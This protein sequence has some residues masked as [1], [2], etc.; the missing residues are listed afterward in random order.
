MGRLGPSSHLVVAALVAVPSGLL[1]GWQSEGHRPELICTW[2][3]VFFATV[4]GALSDPTSRSA[5]GGL[6]VAAFLGCL[7][8]IYVPLTLQSPGA[9]LLQG[10]NYGPWIWEASVVT[11]VATVCFIAGLS[12]AGDR[13]SLAVTDASSPRQATSPRLQAA[14]LVLLSV[15]LVAS[16]AVSGIGESHSATQPAAYLL[17]APQYALGAG[18]F[19]YYL[20]RSKLVRR[21]GGVTCLILTASFAA[22]G[23]RYLALV[24]AAALLILTIWTRGPVRLPRARMFW[25]AVLVGFVALSILGVTRQSGSELSSTSVITSGIDSSDVVLP[26]AAVIK[27]TQ[28]RGFLLGTSYTYLVIQV[29][30]RQVWPGKPTPPTVDVIGEFSDV[31]EGR[32]FPLW[33]EMYLNFG[34][35]GVV[36]GMAA[37]GYFYRRLLR[38]W[39]TRRVDSPGLDVAMALCAPLLVQWMSRGLF[40]QLIYNSAGLLVVPLMLARADRQGRAGTRRGRKI[41]AGRYEGVRLGPTFETSYSGSNLVSARSGI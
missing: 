4:W 24:G 17:Y 19:L 12:L 3:L 32:A 33:G 29:V 25:L 13:R 28:D 34:W 16:A 30:P 1:L 35:L 38:A 6:L 26:L 10:V 15:F 21:I 40:V 7:Y 2:I 20:G 37:I 39:G 9:G 14:A 5:L 22:S 31:R 11:A 8:G 23:V 41:V 36:I 27:R 18:L